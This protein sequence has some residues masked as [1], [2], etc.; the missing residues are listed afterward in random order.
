MSLMLSRELN[1][2]LIYGKLEGLYTE[3]IFDKV[4]TWHTC[5]EFVCILTLCHLLCFY[6]N[7]VN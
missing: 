2:T 4:A 7:I 1:K 5:K 3:A 6:G